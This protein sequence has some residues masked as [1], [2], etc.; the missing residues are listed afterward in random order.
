MRSMSRL[1]PRTDPLSRP[2]S[3]TSQLLDIRNMT[4]SYR[5]R[6]PF[7][8]HIVSVSRARSQDG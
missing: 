1:P 2:R 6:Y 8:A 7:L 5:A 4:G 3:G